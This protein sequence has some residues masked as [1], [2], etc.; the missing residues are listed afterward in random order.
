MILRAGRRV[1]ASTIGHPGTRCDLLRRS[2]SDPSTASAPAVRA[3]SRSAAT[4]G[5]TPAQRGGALSLMAL[6]TEEIPGRFLRH[7]LTMILKWAQDS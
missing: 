2:M 1:P 5:Q 3:S 6:R 4:R 7:R